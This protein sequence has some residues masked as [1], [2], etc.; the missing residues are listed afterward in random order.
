MTGSIHTVEKTWAITAFLELSQTHWLI[1]GYGPIGQT[2]ASRVNAS[3]AE[4]DI[5][6]GSPAS[7]LT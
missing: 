6:R 2:V 3:S 7:W 5:I 4:I 1:I